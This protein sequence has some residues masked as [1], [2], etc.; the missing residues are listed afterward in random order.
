MYLHNSSQGGRAVGGRK[1]MLN[2][3]VYK[4]KFTFVGSNILFMSYTVHNIYETLTW[5]VIDM[6]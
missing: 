4:Q 3:S 1:H 5:I 6:D 2:V